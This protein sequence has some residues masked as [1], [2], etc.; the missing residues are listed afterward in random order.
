[1]LEPLREV[2]NAYRIVLAS[3]SPRR[4]EILENIRL[5]IEILPADVEENLDKEAFQNR[6]HEYAVQTADVKADNVFERV[7]L[8]ENS[9]KLIVIGSDTVVSYQGKIYGK[10]KNEDHAFQTLSMLSGQSHEVYS[11]VKIIHSVDGKSNSVSFYEK[12]EVHF[13]PLTP[14]TI[15]AY[16]NTKEPMDK[17]GGYGIQAIGGTMVK[18]ISGDY[19]NVMGF[20]LHSFCQHLLQLLEK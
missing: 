2:L 12:T 20:P 15:K 1:M 17:A 8:Q 10:P 18:G 11:G 7:K 14:E 13:A 5:P 3:A 16:I 4:K 9:K 6:P 19:F